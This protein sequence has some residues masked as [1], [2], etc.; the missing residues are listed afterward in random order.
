MINLNLGAGLK[1][2]HGFVNIDRYVQADIDRFPAYEL[3]SSDCLSYLRK[4]PDNTISSIYTRHFLEHIDSEELSEMLH[5]FRR[6]CRSGARLIIIVPHW[7][8]PYYF[9]DPT[10]RT[11]FGLYTAAYWC[12]NKYF[13]RGIPAY[14]SFEEFNLER[15][16]LRYKTPIKILRLAGKLAN[17]LLNSS[18]NFQEFAEWTLT[19]YIS[20]YEVEFTITIN[21][22]L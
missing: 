21:K 18:A 19:K 8:N 22:C 15:V 1:P 13:R 9:S 7:S 4:Q 6:V 20:I 3:V 17:F 11:F 5:E 10:H 2:K 16:Y 14:A 12:K